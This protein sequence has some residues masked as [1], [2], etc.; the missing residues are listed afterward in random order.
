MLEMDGYPLGYRNNNTWIVPQ[1]HFFVMGDNRDR[2][3]DSREWGFV[4]ENNL[5]GRAM[6][7]WLNCSGWVCVDGFDTSRIG[8]KIE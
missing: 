7:I 5:V 4:P 3:A 6:W 8:T 1:D 2:S